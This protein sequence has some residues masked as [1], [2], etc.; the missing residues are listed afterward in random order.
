MTESKFR[1]LIWLNIAL[2]LAGASA[3]L[4][5]NT[6]S[7]ELEAAFKNEPASWPWMSDW[8]L[9]G[10]AALFLIAWIANIVGLLLFKRWARALALF[11][12]LASLLLL[13]SGSS[14][15]TGLESAFYEAATLCWGAVLA[16]AYY[17]PVSERFNG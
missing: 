16:L 13:T 8:V 9:A 5:P 1:L 6:F 3:A 12:T 2:T 11:T 15:F 17:S 10:I 4:L 14:L 7:I